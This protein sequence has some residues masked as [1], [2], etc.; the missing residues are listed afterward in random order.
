MSHFVFMEINTYY[1]SIIPFIWVS[2]VVYCS[3]LRLKLERQ[4]RSCCIL[5]S[6]PQLRINT[7]RGWLS[8][9]NLDYPRYN[10]MVSEEKLKKDVEKWGFQHVK[11]GLFCNMKK[12]FM[13]EGISPK[14]KITLL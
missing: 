12:Q 7:L 13:W 11:G 4:E 8:G 1:L 5:S 9:T 2:V 10:K 3:K 6:C 14:P